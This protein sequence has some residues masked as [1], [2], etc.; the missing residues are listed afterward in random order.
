MGSF[1]SRSLRRQEVPLRLVTLVLGVALVACQTA[2]RTVEGAQGRAGEAGW[3]EA[4][5]RLRKRL[6]ARLTTISKTASEARLHSLGFTRDELA[7][8]EVIPG[9]KIIY[10]DL[11][12][13]RSAPGQ[14]Q[15]GAGFQGVGEVLFPFSLSPNGPHAAFV[16]NWNE[17]KE[18]SEEVGGEYV[19]KLVNQ[20]DK[21]AKKLNTGPDEL[22]ILRIYGAGLDQ[23]EF[24]AYISDTGV[25]VV[26]FY[27]IPGVELEEG[28]AYTLKEV[29]TK[30]DSLAQ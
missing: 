17:S 2:D 19:G 9:I 8:A 18:S 4:E 22:D 11:D 5:L 24:I 26:P 25:T 3:E 23:L 27:P 7:K 14:F 29:V 10:F 28:E 30:V 12:A 16:E 1:Q 21:S 15:R 6:Q 20:I 13:A